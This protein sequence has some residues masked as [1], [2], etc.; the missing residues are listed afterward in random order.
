MRD[1]YESEIT[2]LIRD[3]LEKNPHVVQEQKRARARWWDKKLDLHE[4]KRQ[5]ESF[6]PRG[7]YYYYDNPNAPEESE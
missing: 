2:L 3:L 5:K 1:L 4:L 7:G 6:V